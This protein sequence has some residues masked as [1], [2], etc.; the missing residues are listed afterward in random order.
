MPTDLILR[1]VP[2]FGPPHARRYAI[3][4]VETGGYFTGAGFSWDQTKARL[5]HTASSACF[6]MHDILRVVY[7]AK[8]LKRYEVPIEMEVYGDVGKAN[9]ARWLSQSTVL[10]IRTHEF[11]NGPGNESLVLPVVH[12]GLIQELARPMFSLDEI[13]IEEDEE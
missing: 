4:N 9:V 6:Q 8:P 10:N 3:V 5:Y 12:W 11:G 1:A 2:E 13:D 7:G